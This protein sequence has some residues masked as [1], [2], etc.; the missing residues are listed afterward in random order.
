M[1]SNPVAAE[2]SRRLF[3]VRLNLD[4][5]V[6]ELKELLEA[7]DSGELGELRAVRKAGLDSYLDIL[8]STAS[9]ID[10]KLTLLE[11]EGGL[12]LANLRGLPNGGAK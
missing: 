6:S 3:Y 9:A 4:A 12:S 2:V 7:R 11:T 5:A 10:S 1:P 8:R